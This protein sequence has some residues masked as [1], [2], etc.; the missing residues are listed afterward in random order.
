MARAVRDE[1][2]HAARLAHDVE[3]RLR[4]LPA[5]RLD[6]GADVVDASRRRLVQHHVDR[7]AVVL[8]VDEVAHR[9]PVLVQRQLHS[10]DR[11]GDEHRNQF[12][13]VLIG[14]VVVGA[15]RDQHRQAEAFRV[16]LSDVLAAGLAGR[17]RAPWA[18]RVSLA[19]AARGHVAVHLIGAYQQEDL[20]TVLAGGHTQDRG[21]AH[22]CLDEYKGVEQGAVDMRLG[23]EVD[24]RVDAACQL[25]D[26]AGVTDVALDEAVAWLSVEFGEVGGVARVRELV[27]HGDLDLWPCRAQKAHE[28]GPDEA[29]A[30]GD[31]E[32]LERTR[33][34]L[35]GGPA[36]QS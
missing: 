25:V 28:V 36:V 18:Q 9:R 6:T 31:K 13:R 32:A 4:H 1:L 17:V 14:P 29:R 22:V 24:D 8:D 3:H 21:A 2:D 35:M 16:R 15:A 10:V 33:A 20:V 7:A 27:E 11:I 30:S 5:A 23:C 12:L 34:H 26:E 19:R